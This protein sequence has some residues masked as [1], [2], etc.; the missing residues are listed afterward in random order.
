MHNPSIGQLSQQSQHHTPLIELH[1]SKSCQQ[2]SAY[3]YSIHVLT[4]NRFWVGS[5]APQPFVY[6]FVYLPTCTVL[7]LPRACNQMNRVS[8]VWIAQASEGPTL[9]VLSSTII[10]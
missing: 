2:F 8:G 6:P 7:G 10:L 3:I 9:V 5:Q 4:S 1:Y